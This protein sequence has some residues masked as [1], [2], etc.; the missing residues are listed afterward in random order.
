VE[1]EQDDETGSDMCECTKPAMTWTDPAMTWK[2][3]A[4]TW[5]KP[6]MIWTKPAMTWKE[7]RGVGAAGGRHR[8]INDR[9]TEATPRVADGDRNTEGGRR[10]SKRG[11]FKCKKIFR[12]SSCNRRSTALSP[13]RGP[14]LRARFGHGGDTEGGE[15]EEAALLQPPPGS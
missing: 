4:M 10:R 5:T 8:K 2:E 11:A 3:P 12:R 14:D 1:T 7:T 9:D 15:A 6:A 13:R